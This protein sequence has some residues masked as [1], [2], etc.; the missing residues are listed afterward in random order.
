MPSPY[1]AHIGRVRPPHPHTSLH[2]VTSAELGYTRAPRHHPTQ[3]DAWVERAE[4]R[5]HLVLHVAFAKYDRLLHTRH[6]QPHTAH[7]V[8]V[9]PALDVRGEHARV[10]GCEEGRLLEQRQR[11][12]AR[13]PCCAP[14]ES[15][16]S[17][18]RVFHTCWRAHWVLEN[19]RIHEVE[20]REEGWAD[21]CGEGAFGNDLLK[22]HL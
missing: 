13:W 7:R 22:L 21:K 18:I 20:R 17:E 15:A 16:Q 14:P 4:P 8:W 19:D 2:C 5:E 10:P 11:R 12:R 3:R 6:F 1:N 9:K